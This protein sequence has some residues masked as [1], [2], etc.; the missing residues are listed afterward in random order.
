M[1]TEHRE[2][3]EARGWTIYESNSQ[4]ELRQGSPAGEDFSF[5]ADG[6]DIVRSVQEYAESFDE[7]EHI[8]LWIDARRSGVGGVPSTRELV[9]DA[10]AIHQMLSVLSRDLQEV[11]A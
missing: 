10:A 9:E 2:I 8:E 7:D 5:V 3:I 6:E 1:K 11:Q 4:V